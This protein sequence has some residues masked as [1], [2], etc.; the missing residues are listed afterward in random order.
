ME[1]ILALADTF[2]ASLVC[3]FLKQRRGLNLIK[4][5]WY[6]FHGLQ[7]V[8]ANHHSFGYKLFHVAQYFFFKRY[9]LRSKKYHKT[10]FYKYLKKQGKTLLFE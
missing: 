8:V 10:F 7:P 6:D 1:T 5:C 9:L 3:Y 4:P 2:S